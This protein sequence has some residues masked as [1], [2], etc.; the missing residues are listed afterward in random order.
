MST[1]EK[2]ITP[3]LVIVHWPGKDTPACIEH[4]EKLVA[5]GRAMGFGV[6]VTP[7]IQGP[8][9]PMIACKNCENEAK[10]P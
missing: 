9:E 4:A 10:K 6:S 7:F 3:A 2:Q 1:E 5:L 8:D